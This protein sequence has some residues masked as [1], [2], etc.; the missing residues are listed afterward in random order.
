MMRLVAAYMRGVCGVVYLELKFNKGEA[1]ESCLDCGHQG[2]VLDVAPL[3]VAEGLSPIV[4]ENQKRRAKQQVMKESSEGEN[5]SIAHGGPIYIPNLVGPL[6]SIPEFQSALLSEL[7]NL[8]SELSLDSSELLNDIDLSVDELKIFSEEELVDMALKEAFKDDENIGSSSEPFAECSNGRF[9]MILLRSDTLNS[10]IMYAQNS[11]LP[12][13]RICLSKAFGYISCFTIDEYKSD[14][15]TRIVALRQRWKM[16]VANG[17][18]H[19][20]WDW[21]NFDLV[22]STS[23]SASF[24]FLFSI[25]VSAEMTALDCATIK[26]HSH[27]ALG[28]EGTLQLLWNHQMDL[29]LAPV[30]SYL[31]KV[32][33]LVKIKQKQDEDKA[34]ACL[35]S[36]NCK[37]NFSGIPSLCRT[38]TMQS[39]RSTNLNQPKSSV[40]QEHTPVMVPEVVIC[41]EIYH[42]IRKWLKTQEFFVLGGQTLTEMRDKIYCLT[43]QV[44]Q[45][46]GQHDPS[47]YFLVEDVFCNDLRD[48]S[49]IDYS[50]PIIDWLR[51]QKADALRKWECIISGDLQQKQKAVVGE[52]TT[53]SLPQLRRV[54]MQNTRFCDLRFRLG[55]GYLYCHQGD[56]KHTIVF[57]DMR[58]IHPDDL[59]NLAAYPIVSFQIKF[60]TQKCMVCRIYRAVKVTVDDKWAPDNPCYFCKD[61]YY[62]LHH[63]EDGSLLYSGFSAYDYVHD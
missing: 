48:T 44:M 33:G 47:G 17:Q 3:P 39:L 60:R 41:V 27:K 35:H 20:V 42:N 56:C 50:E 23:L 1:I 10:H 52:S 37:I 54:N 4:L 7:Q 30:E 22:E 5:E 59:Q 15:Q 36:F 19:L 9:I 28:Q 32:D 63:S 61:C 14:L 34:M 25:F 21:D 62:L 12:F 55:A 45:K 53:P 51:N 6:T 38:K 26:I 31:T 57:R 13:P 8:Q 49:A 29:I 11:C 24:C 2:L 58:L 43:D 46:A 16:I 18:P 40:V